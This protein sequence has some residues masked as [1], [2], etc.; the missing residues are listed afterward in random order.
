MSFYL[1]SGTIKLNASSSDLPLI[2]SLL[3]EKSTCSHI[4]MLKDGVKIFPKGK[5]LK[6]GGSVVICT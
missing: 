6:A 4:P 5:V 1:K 2:D 3:R